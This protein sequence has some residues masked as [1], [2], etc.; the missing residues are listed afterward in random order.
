MDNIHSNNNKIMINIQVLKK[1][2]NTEVNYNIMK[3]HKQV[4][5]IYNFIFIIIEKYKTV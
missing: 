3:D 4:F 2:N 5:F 1:I